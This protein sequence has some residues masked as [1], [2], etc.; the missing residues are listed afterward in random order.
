[1]ASSD[2]KLAVIVSSVIDLL[3]SAVLL[4]LSLNFIWK[5][6]LKQSINKKFVNIFYVVAIST[7]VTI[8]VTAIVA[9]AEMDVDVEIDL[10]AEISVGGTMGVLLSIHNVCYIGLITLM[11]CTTI[12]IMVGLKNL[13]NGCDI[14]ARNRA[15]NQLLMVYFAC[16]IIMLVTILVEVFSNKGVIGANF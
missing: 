15:R 16:A 2:L 8:F 13:A 10:N 9:L 7:C 3:I 12:Q 1:M 6:I 4:I 14:I 5:F 11:I